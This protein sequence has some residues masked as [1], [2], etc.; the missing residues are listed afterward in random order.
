MVRIIVQIALLM[1][2]VVAAAL[3]GY[4]MTMLLLYEL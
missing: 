4:W 2:A 3:S 1:T